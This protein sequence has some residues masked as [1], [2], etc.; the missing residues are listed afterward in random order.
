MAS[1]VRLGAQEM[2]LD[3]RHVEDGKIG[4]AERAVG[5]PV[6]GRDASQHAA[7][8]GKDVDHTAGPANSQPAVA[9][10]L[11][12]VSRHMPS[13]PRCGEVVQHSVRTERAVVAHG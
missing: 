13:M 11:P 3:R 7:V 6:G 10:M 5:R 9:M 1:P 2:A 4:T 8:G 12:S